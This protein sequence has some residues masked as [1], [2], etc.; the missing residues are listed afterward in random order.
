[1]SPLAEYL[2]I[3]PSLVTCKDFLGESSTERVFSGNN[4]QS[5]CS[6]REKRDV[7]RW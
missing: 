2:C 3:F 1:M 4:T 7:E 5:I 6:E